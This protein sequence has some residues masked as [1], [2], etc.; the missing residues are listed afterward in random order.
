[1]ERNREGGKGQRGDHSYRLAFAGVDGESEISLA[2]A[3]LVGVGEGGTLGI[4]CGSR[5][6]A[7]LLPKLLLFAHAAVAAAASLPS[8][9]C[10]ATTAARYKPAAAAEMN[11]PVVAA[12]RNNPAIAAAGKRLLSDAPSAFRRPL[13]RK[14]TSQA[15]AATARNASAAA[16]GDSIW[17]RR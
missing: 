12:A 8:R 15:A 7:P 5:P 9:R 17:G 2:A 14:K 10:P 1:M 11:K 4:C 16:R 13:R 3:E 6:C